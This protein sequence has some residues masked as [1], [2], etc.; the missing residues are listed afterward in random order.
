M[1]GAGV[2]VDDEGFGDDDLRPWGLA[3]DPRAGGDE[4]GRLAG[5]DRDRLGTTTGGGLLGL[6]KSTQLLTVACVLG[7]PV[8][9][10]L[11]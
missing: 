8:V 6:G 2:G 4:R 11:C 5:G 3:G 10:F 1:A 7:Q 9:V